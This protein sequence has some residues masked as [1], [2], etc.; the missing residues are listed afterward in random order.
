MLLDWIACQLI[1]GRPIKTKQLFLFGL[2][3]TQKS[4]IIN[5]ISKALR[6]YFASSRRN[7]F[8]DADNFYDLWVFDEFHEPDSESSAISSTEAGTA[9]ANML[10]LL[11]RQECRLD[12]KYSGV[13]LKKRNPLY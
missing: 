12:S 11:D 7:D 10:Q 3:S 2:P 8:A 1:F 4:L 9:F 6:V 5:F 13:F